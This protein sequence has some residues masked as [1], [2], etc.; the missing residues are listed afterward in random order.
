MCA[1]AHFRVDVRNKVYAVANDNAND[2]SKKGISFLRPKQPSFSLLRSTN[3]VVY[4][5]AS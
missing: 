4:L 1:D 2:V 5:K 3:V